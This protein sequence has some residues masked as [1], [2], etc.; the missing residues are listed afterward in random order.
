MK[1]Q[2]TDVLEEV[3][4]LV[5]VSEVSSHVRETRVVGIRLHQ[6]RQE[7]KKLQSCELER[8]MERERG[9]GRLGGEGEGEREM[10]REIEGERKGGEGERKREKERGR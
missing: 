1:L 10:K 4:L 6:R 3:D 8:E 7:R 2:M 9:R 5:L